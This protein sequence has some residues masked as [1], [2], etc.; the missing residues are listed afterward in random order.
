VS[1]RFHGSREQLLL[2][3]LLLLPLRQQQ[4]L[5]FNTQNNTAAQVLDLDP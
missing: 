3:L 1:E 4:Q 5:R 2:L